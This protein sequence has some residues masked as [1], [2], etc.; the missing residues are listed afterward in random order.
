MKATVGRIVHYHNSNGDGPFAALVV[1]AEDE[2]GTIN[3]SVYSDTGGRWIEKDL[4]QI[5]DGDA[6]TDKPK[7][8][9]WPPRE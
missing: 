3:A 9:R 8:W 7:G 1:R 6:M 4:P 2:A 5:K